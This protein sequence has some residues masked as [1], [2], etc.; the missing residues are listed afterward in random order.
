MNKTYITQGIA[1]L[2]LLAMVFSVGLFFGRTG[3]SGGFTV[4]TEYAI[5]AMSL[6]ELAIL[7]EAQERAQNRVEMP[8]QQVSELSEAVFADEEVAVM[9]DG[10]LNLNVA[11]ITA[12]QT[13]PGIGPVMAQRIIDHREV[14]GYFRIIE[15]LTDVSGIGPARFADIRDLIVVK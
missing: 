9:I 15:Q 10:R 11:D 7:A 12:L 6:D 5:G 1:A 8:D 3:G 4:A 13:L 14:I 2:V